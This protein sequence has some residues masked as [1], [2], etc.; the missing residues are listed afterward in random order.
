[1]R[2][3]LETFSYHLAFRAGTINILTFIERCVSLGLD[4]VQLNTGHMDAFLHEDSG[5]VRKVRELAAGNNLFVEV[6][7]RGTDP[8]HLAN[9]LRLCR[10]LGADTLRTYASCGGDL[11]EELARAPAHLRSMIPMCQEFGI[12]IA[13]ENHEYETSQE[14]VEIVQQ[15]DSEWVGTHVDTGNSMMVWEEPVDAVRAMAPLAVSTHF[16]DH[17]V[18]MEDG[19][20]LVL[21]TTLGR[22]NIDCR[23]VLR[24]LAADSSLERLVIEDCYGY[25]APF[26]RPEAEGAGGRLGEGAFRLVE[27][28][29]DPTWALL[30]PREAAPEEMKKFITWQEASVIRSVDFVKGLMA[31]S[32]KT[33]Q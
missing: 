18:I 31:E 15:V 19:Q 16:K 9:R 17:I 26:R 23:E 22:G 8:G 6:D 25:S 3:G 24:I 7:A 4:G 28:P 5:R 30:H 20:P 12:R 2:L 11:A 13:L 27:G 33:G 21:A 1:M 32:A 10:D 29:L 14:I